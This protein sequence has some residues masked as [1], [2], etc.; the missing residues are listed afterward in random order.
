MDEEVITLL[1]DYLWNNVDGKSFRERN[2]EKEP[3]IGIISIP[4][5]TW[6]RLGRPESINVQLRRVL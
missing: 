1:F 6:E 3:V 4:V 2:E 5:P